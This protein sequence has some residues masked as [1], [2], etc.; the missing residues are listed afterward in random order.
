MNR[1]SA[2][3]THLF[4]TATAAAVACFGLLAPPA[5]SAAPAEPPLR[6]GL[7]LALTGEMSAPS[8]MQKNGYLLWERDINAR[9]GILNRRVE[10]VIRDD[11]GDRATAQQIYKDLMQR[12]KVDFLIGPYSSGI[13]AAVAGIVDKAGYPMLAPG[14][15]ADS[16]W[17]NG[18]TYIFGIHHHG[19][20]FSR[21]FL[22]MLADAGIGKIAIISTLDDPFAQDM[23]IGTARWAKEYGLQVVL[24]QKIS[25]SDTNLDAAATAARQSGAEALLMSGQVNGTINMRRALKNINWTPRAYF[26]ALGPVLDKYREVLGPDAEG[27]FTF[28]AWEPIEELKLPGSYEFLQAYRKMYG[29]EPGYHAALAYASGQVMER[30]I[31]KAGR[32]DSAAVREELVRLDADIIVGRYAVDRAGSQTKM[33]TLITQWQGGRRQV[34]WPLDLRTAAPI[35]YK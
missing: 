14:A 7:S 18:Y 32:V 15:S 29:S 33:A 19:S 21:G 17:K 16:I 27:A 30:A 3:M 24:D 6:F 10:I 26:A 22:A 20:R 25:K 1:L 28:S 35:I 2:R 4:S 9:G 12:D 23:A 5:A 11:K 34:V 13:T 8:N 31:Q